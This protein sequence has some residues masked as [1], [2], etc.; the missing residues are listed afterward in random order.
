MK[1]F[2][3]GVATLAMMVPGAALAA[4]DGSPG[5]TSSGSFN[6][7]MTVEPP[8]GVT[9]QV[10]G[11][12][13]FDFGTVNTTN[14]AGTSVGVI[15]QPFCL[16]RSDSGD[17]RV[18]IAQTNF[19]PGQ[20]SF[21]L[22]STNPSGPNDRVPVSLVIN[23]LGAGGIGMSNNAAQNFSQS[24]TGC[25]SSSSSPTAHTMEITPSTLPGADTFRLSGAYTGQFTITASVP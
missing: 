14:T 22:E 5:A 3:M 23:N 6:A 8:T 10:L 18:N 11:L 1:R 19:A 2:L 4:V 24:A 21:A 16:L 20:T 12:D 15:T 7:T 13:D 25:S 17:V 9:V